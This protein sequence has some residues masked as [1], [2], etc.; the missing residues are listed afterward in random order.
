MVFNGL[1][2]IR[3]NIIQINYIIPR[4]VLFSKKIKYYNI[5]FNHTINRK[6][7]VSPDTIIY[8]FF[9]KCEVTMELKLIN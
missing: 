9:I 8:Y 7:N 4:E 3:Q 6:K 1:F 2:H 5:H